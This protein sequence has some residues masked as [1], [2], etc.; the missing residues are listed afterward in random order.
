MQ[1]ECNFIRSHKTRKERREHARMT[2][3]VPVMEALR[4]DVETGLVISSPEARAA[5]IKLAIETADREHPADGPGWSKP[6]FMGATEKREAAPLPVR[7]VREDSL[8]DLLIKQSARE[9]PTFYENDAYTPFRVLE[10]WFMVVGNGL[11]WRTDGVLAER[12][13]SSGQETLR[14][15]A[16]K[17]IE[18]EVSAEYQ[19]D[20]KDN[21][22]HRFMRSVGPRA[23]VHL[24]PLS[25]NYSKVFTVPDN[26][27]DS[28]LAA[29]VDI[30]RYF[31]TRPAW[32]CF[33]RSP[34]DE[35]G[36]TEAIYETDD[37]RPMTL[38]NGLE[39]RARVAAAYQVLSDRFKDRLLPMGWV[40]D[41]FK[42]DETLP[43][44]IVVR[45]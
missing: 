37:W 44:L 26:V 42:V 23:E 29:A 11:E 4:V 10:Q 16:L 43:P 33:T 12:G 13:D 21:D 19:R 25:E 8:A 31:L 32:Q 40:E 22:T 28:F 27:E 45:A 36:Q 17:V 1:F 30:C 34:H 15:E 6:Q 3:E 38:Q 18:A 7:L 2:F 14:R 41:E 20:L 39:Y 35:D 24:Y 9:Y 5:F